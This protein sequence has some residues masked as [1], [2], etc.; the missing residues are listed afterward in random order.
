MWQ[1]LPPIRSNDQVVGPL[2]R[3]SR[4]EGRAQQQTGQKRRRPQPP[5][6]ALLHLGVTARS[7]TLIEYQAHFQTQL[8]THY[9]NRYSRSD[10]TIKNKFLT[11]NEHNG[12]RLKDNKST[13]FKSWLFNCPSRVIF[14]Q[15]L[16]NIV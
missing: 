2:P 5:H 11:G 8:N 3:P 10:S 14:F 16:S 6:P 15:P 9:I 4:A 7:H 13:N 12:L 1:T